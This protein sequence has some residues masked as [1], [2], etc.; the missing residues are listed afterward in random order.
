MYEDQH[1]RE[2]VK[3]NELNDSTSMLRAK[4][5]MKYIAKRYF[6]QPNYLKVNGKPI[7]LDFGPQWFTTEEQWTEVFS[8][9]GEQQPAFYALNY[10]SHFAGRNAVGEYGWI[11]GDYLA[12]LQHFYNTFEYSG[13]KIG[14]AYPGFV[15]YYKD[16]NWGD[17]IGWNIPHRGDSTFTETLQLALSSKPEIIQLAT[18]NDYGEGTMI[19]PTR[20]FGYTFLA[21]L[22]RELGVKN[23]SPK[24]FELVFDFYNAR[25]NHKNDASIQLQL[26]RAFALIAALRLDEARKIITSV[27]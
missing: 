17:G 11:Y 22:Q 20:E 7:F 12:G 23:L 21:T 24:D 1:L 10:H 14:V 26:D 25:I 27:K 8:A 9:F 16:G 3:R 18:W 4:E 13:D 15:D 19:E 6:T 2:A 5:D